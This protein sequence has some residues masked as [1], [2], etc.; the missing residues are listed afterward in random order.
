MFA[1]NTLNLLL[2][3]LMQCENQDIIL[4]YLLHF[5]TTRVSTLYAWCLEHTKTGLARHPVKG[6]YRWE[7]KELSG[8]CSRSV[9]LGPGVVWETRLFYLQAKT[10]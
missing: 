4:L 1:I 10:Q 3:N 5:L 6:R 9:A 8:L 2:L 7:L